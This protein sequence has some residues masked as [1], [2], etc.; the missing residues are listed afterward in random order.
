M[1]SVFLRIVTE[2]WSILCEMSPYLLFGFVVAGILS[3]IVSAAWVER[4]L[5]GRG[6]AP[7][8]KASLF[9]IPLPLCSCGIIPV[10]ASIRHHGSS[11]AAT[12]SFML[13]T[14]QT[15]VDSIAITYGMLGPVFAVFRPLA[16]LVTGLVGGTLVNLLDKNGS[17]DR[18]EGT[19][20]RDEC[21]VP[22]KKRNSLTRIADYGLIRLPGDIGI[23]LLV[24]VLISGVIT[25][26]VPEDFLSLYIGSSF[27]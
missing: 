11:K 18:V 24:G 22:S 19:V 17:A 3:I 9:G 20:C 8:L 1:K 25:V 23:A 10:A 27:L 7:I 13:S 16:A 12:T 21:C 2:S 4:N 14:P 6:F 5:G 26:L 15:G